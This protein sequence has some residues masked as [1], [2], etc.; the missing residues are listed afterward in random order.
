MMT[1]RTVMKV[2]SED[3]TV[4]EFFNENQNLRFSRVPVYKDNADNITGQV[5]KDE[6]FKEM[7]NQNGHKTL[8]G[9][10]RPIIFTTRNLPIPDLFNEL[11]QTKNHIALVV[12]EYGSV[13]GLVTMEDVIETLLGLEIVDESDTDANMQDLAR[14]N[15][16][17][18]AR[19]LGIL[20]DDE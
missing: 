16:E 19:K 6:V 2:A 7:A 14:K 13:S 20:E 12:D 1:P 3:T 17:N 4:Q 18:R 15:W 5:L 11:I 8:A 10:K 9:I